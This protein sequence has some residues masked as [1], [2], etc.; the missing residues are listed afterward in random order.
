[1]KWNFFCPKNI[2][3]KIVHVNMCVC[4]RERERESVCVCVCVR[5]IYI[6]SESVCA[7]DRYR[8]CVCERER[9]REIVCVC[10]YMKGKRGSKFMLVFPPHSHF[11]ANSVTECPC[12]RK[13]RTNPTMRI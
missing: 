12:L 9:E 3:L 7:R 8:V 2:F 6:Y 5:N 11:R 4:V 10:V 1:M 13:P